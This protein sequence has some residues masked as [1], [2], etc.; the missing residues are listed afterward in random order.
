MTTGDYE[1]ARLHTAERLECFRHLTSAWRTR[2]ART[3]RGGAAPGR[4]SPLCG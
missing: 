3:I 1:A 4:L 2:A